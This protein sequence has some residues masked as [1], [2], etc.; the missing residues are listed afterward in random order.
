MYVTLQ[1]QTAPSLRSKEDL[2]LAKELCI[3]QFHCLTWRMAAYAK[4][5]HS[6]PQKQSLEVSWEVQTYNLSLKIN[7]D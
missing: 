5:L 3:A 2:P 7:T 4:G 1:S 6:L